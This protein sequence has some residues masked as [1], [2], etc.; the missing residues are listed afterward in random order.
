MHIQFGIHYVKG[1]GLA[2]DVYKTHK[3]FMLMNIFHLREF[4]IPFFQQTLVIDEQDINIKEYNYLNFSGCNHICL[5]LKSIDFN[6]FDKYSYDYYQ[7]V[8]G[9]HLIQ[10]QQPFYEQ[11]TVEIVDKENGVVYETFTHRQDITSDIR[12]LTKKQ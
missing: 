12:R 9:Q 8:E 7:D 1:W 10:V 3:E 6:C 5:R 11:I 2:F 4:A